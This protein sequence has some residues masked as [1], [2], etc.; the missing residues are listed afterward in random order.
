M[1][2]QLAIVLI[3]IMVATPAM[4]N[5]KPDATAAPR[6]EA[7]KACPKSLDTARG[8]SYRAFVARCLRTTRKPEAPL[9]TP[10]RGIGA[11]LVTQGSATR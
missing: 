5:N 6:F 2:R 4:A 8:K 9:F 11:P 7:R 3:S 1:L 10:D